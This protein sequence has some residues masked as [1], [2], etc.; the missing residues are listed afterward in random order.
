MDR[1]FLDFSAVLHLPVRQAMQR[2]FTIYPDD[3]PQA[4]AFRAKQI[5]AVLRLTPL[6]M[7]ANVVNALLVAKAFWPVASHAFL[8]FWVSAVFIAALAGGRSW[9]AMRRGALRQTASPRALR[10]AAI[11]ASA[12]AGD[13]PGV[14]F[15][16]R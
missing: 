7:L 12:P 8:I 2:L 13:W 16:R 10:R 11:H 3:E 4:P 14:V 9:F 5:Q 6:T 15:L 1:F